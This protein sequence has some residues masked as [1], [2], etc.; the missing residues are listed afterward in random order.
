[1]KRKQVLKAELAAGGAGLL[2][3][4]RGAANDGP[5]AVKGQ[6]SMLQHLCP[7]D[8]SPPVLSRPSPPSKPFSAPLPVKTPR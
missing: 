6:T 8:G 4:S 7:L 5:P 3:C 2:G 1:M